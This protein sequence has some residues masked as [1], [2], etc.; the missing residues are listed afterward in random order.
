MNVTFIGLGIMGQRMARHL[1]NHQFCLTVYNRSPEP[2]R[3]LAEQGARMAASLAE[4][5]QEADIVFTMLASPE[6]VEQVAFGEEGFL[7]HMRSG[8]LWTD[9][10]TVNP[11]FSRMAHQ[12]AGQH[13]VHFVDAPVSGSK[14]QAESA[15]LVF[16]VGGATSDVE[17]VIPLLKVMSKKIVHVGEIG[18]GTSLKMLVNALLAQSMVLFSEVL[19]LGEKMGLSRDFLLDTLPGL[20]VSP[21]FIQAKAEKIRQQD[22]AP[23]FPM[24]LMY[25]DLHLAALTAYEHRQPL[26][27]A[28]L[29]KDLYAQ[30]IQAGLGREDF[31]AVH[32]WMGGEGT[33]GKAAS[34]PS[35]ITGAELKV[36]GEFQLN[37][38]S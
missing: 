4:A 14:P 38:L 33:D 18:Q 34:S 11:S 23:Q 13:Q 36:T 32:K 6:A 21:P 24:E 17:Q 5:V 19:H 9:C 12:A 37:T 31:S 1:L 29:A 2:A 20:P 28:N 22:Y 27:L 16:F 7:P 26:F 30:A 10:S 8:A 3:Q 35:S 25:K 15:E